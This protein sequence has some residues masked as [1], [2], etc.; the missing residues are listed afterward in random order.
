MSSPYDLTQAK[1]ETMITNFQE[2]GIG[3]KDPISQSEIL[4][5][6]N[7][8]SRSGK[9]D[10]ALISKLFEEMNITSNS[11]LTIQEFINGY[12][13]FEESLK[14]NFENFEYKLAQEREIYLNL[15]EQCR[16][17]K[18]EHLNSEGFCENAKVTLEITDV[19]IRRKL[20]GIKEI[21]IRVIYNERV[22]NIRFEIGGENNNSLNKKFEFKPTSRKDHFEFIMKGVNDRNQIFDIG[23]KVFPLDD[24]NSQEEYSVQIIIPEID[25]EDA[26]AAYI[27]AKIILY[28][29]DYKFYERQRKKAEKKLRKLTEAAAKAKDYFLKITEIYGNLQEKKP[30]IIVDFNNEKYVQKLERKLVGVYKSETEE[31]RRKD[32]KVEYNNQKDTEIET[33]KPVSVEFNNEKKVYKSTSS[34]EKTKEPEN[35]LQVIVPQKT[36]TTTME[37]PPSII[38]RLNPVQVI[39]RHNKPIIIDHTKNVLIPKENENNQTNNIQAILDKMN[40]NANNVPVNYSQEASQVK[41]EQSVI[42]KPP[43]V[44]STSLKPINAG[45]SVK[46]PI[47]I[48]GKNNFSFGIENFD[49]QNNNIPISNENNYIPNVS[50]EQNNNYISENQQTDNIIPIN[51]QK[52]NI[53]PSDNNYIDNG[54]NPQIETGTF[55]NNNIYLNNNNQPYPSIEPNVPSVSQKISTDAQ[56]LNNQNYIPIDGGSY[57]GQP[58]YLNK[59][60]PPI[61]GGVNVERTKYINTQR[62]PIDGGVSILPTNDLDIKSTESNY[63]NTVNIPVEQGGISNGQNIPLYDQSITNVDQQTNLYDNQNIPIIPNVENGI[64]NNENY[65]NNNYISNEDLQN[66]QNIPENQQGVLLDQNI[67]TDYY[68]TQNQNIDSNIPVGNIPQV[69]IP[70]TTDQNYLNTNVSVEQST[71]VLPVNYDTNKNYGVNEENTFS[72]QNRYINGEETTN[73]LQQ[74]S[75]IQT[76]PAIDQNTY[77]NG[78]T[79]ST[80]VNQQIDYINAQNIPIDKGTTVSSTTYLNAKENMPIDQGTTVYP[81]TYLNTQE[82]ITTSIAQNNYQT[83]INTVQ[84]QAIKPKTYVV[85][86]GVN[87]LP[88]Q[89]INNQRST[90]IDENINTSLSSSLSQQ[91]INS[92]KTPIV[93]E[94][95]SPL[96]YQN[97]KRD[98]IRHTNST[99]ALYQNNTRGVIV[100]KPIVRQS[101]I[102]HSTTQTVYQRTVRNPIVQN[103][104]RERKF[105]QTRL[106]TISKSSVSPT[107]KQLKYRNAVINKKVLPGK[108]LP[109]TSTQPQVT[110]RTRTVKYIGPIYRP[111]I[112]KKIVRANSSNNIQLT[113]R[114]Y[115]VNT[116]GTNG[117]RTF[118]NSTVDINNLNNGSRVSTS[119]VPVSHLQQIINN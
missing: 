40:Q 7:K 100:E 97:G 91:V 92:T 106:N 46:P 71:N 55:E 3:E 118:V 112:I 23:S 115:L 117:R 81:T 64:L 19:D 51:E 17:Y 37:R 32:L 102:R 47:Y 53:P 50:Y 69:N 95:T 68:N 58:T 41:L 52:Y 77:I 59:Q 98:T 114:D 89:Y 6:L 78:Q 45:V 109:N 84:T 42:T 85:N 9:F 82:N 80:Q 34:K 56:Y 90:I 1:I 54:Q 26:V 10:Q 67:N 20:E 60:N 105:S 36:T 107:Q 103:I 49:N 14:K 76:V 86:T 29:S 73:Y 22:E 72:D 35:D 18:A 21:I 5:F 57:I 101:I 110:S 108:T 43:Q 104:S 8:Y 79:T 94:I 2:I 44:L 12:L 87:I 111:L 93:Q 88:P 99:T 13:T 30:D 74:T 38:H 62:P 31:S 70:V 28:S 48:N 65:E 4:Y 16:K 11:Q 63:V 33:N 116:S 83:D 25:D 113:N 66:I 119:V 39:E 61:Y 96:I 15:E 27:N 75:P 24:V